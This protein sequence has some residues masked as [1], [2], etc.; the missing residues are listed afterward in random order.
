MI[1]KILNIRIK[2]IAR[3]AS[4][5]GIFRTIFLFGFIASFLSILFIKTEGNK[6]EELMIGIFSLSILFIHLKRKDKEFLE[7]NALKP[8]R[9]LLTEYVII[10]APLI[11]SLLYRG[12]WNY[13]IIYLFTLTLISFLK[14]I[15]KKSSLN[16]VFQK[17][18]PDEN[19]EWKSGIRKYLLLFIV[20]WPVGLFT[21][22]FVASV[23]IAIFILGA[24]VLSFY[25]KPESLQMLIAGELNTKRFLMKKVKSQ[26]LYFS[27]LILPLVLS[28]IIFHPRY[29]YIPLLEYLIFII[30]IIYTILLKYAFYQPANKSGA[31]QIFTMIGS[32]CLFIPVFIPVI[33][34]LSI[35][36]LFQAS[37]KLKFYLNDF[38]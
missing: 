30:L 15:P 37:H 26:L 23:P 17:L 19:F 31:I 16:T 18:I 34:L 5:I 33:L 1:V 24:V 12:L 35:K 7:I 38:N 2:Q 32:F 14:I 6:Y 9:I 36:F 8:Q 29:Y 20:I 10:S 27:I 25:E 13:L 4:Q 28:F 22:F 21:S 11:I 3:I